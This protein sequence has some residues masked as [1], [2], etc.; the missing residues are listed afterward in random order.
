MTFSLWNVTLLSFSFSERS[1][2]SPLLPFSLSFFEWV[3]V[4]LVQKLIFYIIFLNI[5]HLYV[6][7][8]FIGKFNI[9]WVE[10]IYT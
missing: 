7:V 5:F 6:L 2:G 1:Y 4:K 9:H 8:K 10:S 3:N